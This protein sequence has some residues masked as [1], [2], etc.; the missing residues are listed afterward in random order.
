MKW[1]NRGGEMPNHGI[2][3]DAGGESKTLAN[4]LVF[5]HFGALL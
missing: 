3:R 1:T 4:F 2:G 5:V